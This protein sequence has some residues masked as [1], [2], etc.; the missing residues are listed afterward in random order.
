VRDGARPAVAI[1]ADDL[2][3][4]SRLG[5]MTER[6]GCIPRVSRTEEAFAA[7]LAGAAG[8]IVDLSVRG[9]DPFAAIGLAARSGPVVAVGPHE[10]SAARK[11]ALAAGAVRVFAYRK[12]HDDGPRTIARAFGLAPSGAAE[13][14]TVEPGPGPGPVTPGSEPVAAR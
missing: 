2:I 1:L 3:W 12:L 8:A 7:S 4:A 6:A 9:S 5:S 14:R 11:R 13:D 10:D